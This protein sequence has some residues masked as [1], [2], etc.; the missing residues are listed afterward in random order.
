MNLVVLFSALLQLGLA[1]ARVAQPWVD[2]LNA[3]IIF[4]NLSTAGDFT[5]ATGPVCN[6]PFPSAEPAVWN[7]NKCRGEKFYDAMHS[8]KE[9]AGKLFQADS[10]HL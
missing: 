7:K 4:T 9:Q 8:T 2:G 3:S 5:I 10:R 6:I 1:C